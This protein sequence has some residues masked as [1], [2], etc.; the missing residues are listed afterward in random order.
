MTYGSAIR[1]SPMCS[2]KIAL[3]LL[4]ATSFSCPVTATGQALTS[5]TRVENAQTIPYATIEAD[6]MGVSPNKPLDEASLRIRS[7]ST[8][9][10]F[11]SLTI[12]DTRS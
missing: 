12:T 9:S 6:R 5:A 1:T 3:L 4:A 2:M 8:R 7:D 10:G 11:M